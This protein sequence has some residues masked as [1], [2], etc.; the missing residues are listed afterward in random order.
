[1]CYILQHQASQRTGQLTEERHFPVGLIMCY[2]KKAVIYLPS[3]LFRYEPALEDYKY[4]IPKRKE[5][6]KQNKSPTV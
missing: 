5:K 1:M 6:R 3:Y 4:F 2:K